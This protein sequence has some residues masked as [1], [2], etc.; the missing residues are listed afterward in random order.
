[1]IAVL[2]PDTDLGD[3]IGALRIEIGGDVT[4]KFAV[5]GSTATNGISGAL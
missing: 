3:D 1:M 4:R 5:A 2:S